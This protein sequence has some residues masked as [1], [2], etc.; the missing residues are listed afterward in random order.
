MSDRKPRILL[1]ENVTA[2]LDALAQYLRLEL[3]EVAACSNVDSAYRE[4]ENRNFDSCI[5][6]LMMDDEDEDQ[7]SG[8]LVLK[9]L[10]ELDEGTLAVILSGQPSTD[11]AARLVSLYRDTLYFSKRRVSQEG[12]APLLQEISTGLRDR[13]HPFKTSEA[14]AG[15]LFG[16]RGTDSV[17]A[18]TNVI[19]RVSPTGGAVALRRVASLVFSDLLPLVPSVRS[20]QSWSNSDAYAVNKVF[21]SRGIGK[22]VKIHFGRDLSKLKE[23]DTVQRLVVPVSTHIGM[24]FAAELVEAPRGDF[25]PC[26]R[27]GRA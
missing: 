20:P 25:L 26:L 18:E 11:A 21:W 14:V 9:A 3:W 5:I 19:S 4:L 27:D 23:Q 10:A 6:D 22:A 1:L 15:Q 16:S 24:E 13:D 7:L 12:Y 2:T 17:I 8:Q